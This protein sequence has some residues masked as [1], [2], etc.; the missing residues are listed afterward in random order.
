MTK[1]EFAALMVSR[2]DMDAL[3]EYA[4]QQLTEYYVNNP[5]QFEQEL[6]NF[7]QGE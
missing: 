3:T 4:E 2:M 1:E 6:Q 7:E 5:E